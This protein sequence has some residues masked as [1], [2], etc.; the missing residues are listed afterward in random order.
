ILA[1]SQV[2]NSAVTVPVIADCDNGYGDAVNVEYLT[3]RAEAVGLAGICIEDSAFP[4]RSSLYNN[5]NQSLVPIHEQVAKIAAAKAAQSDP[6]FTIIARTE[7]LVRKLGFE[8]ALAR[9]FAYVQ[10]GADAI[11]IHST[12]SNADEVIAFAQ[13]WQQRCPLIA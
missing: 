8:E 10:A 12:L 11:L 5:I 13:E 3:R 4:K 6:A 7:S 9:A 1:V 2:I